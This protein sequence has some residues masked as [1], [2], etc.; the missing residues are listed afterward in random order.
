[1]KTLADLW[2]RNASVHRSDIA[3]VCGGR[4]Y[5]YAS[6]VERSWRLAAAL[7]ARSMAPPARIAILG[8]NSAEFL[9]AYGAAEAAGYIAVPLNWRLAPLELAAVLRDCEPVAILFAAPEFS[10]TVAALGELAPARR[11]L[12]AWGE[13]PGWAEPWERVLASAPAVAPDT[14]PTPDDIAAIIY[15]SGTTG[16]PKGV[17]LSH[18]GQV[19]TAA[20]MA[21]ECGVRADDHHLMV[22]PLFHVGAK[23]KQLGYAWRGA[24]IHLEP[25]FD[26]VRVLE[27]VERERIT[28]LHLAPV[29]VQMLLDAPNCRSANVSSIHTVHYASAPM[30]VAHLRRAVAAFGPI[31]QQFYGMTESPL[32]TVLRKHEH[33]PLDAPR[34]ASAGRPIPSAEVR[35]VGVDGTDRPPGESGEVLVRS[36]ALMAGYWN[37]TAASLEALAGGWMHTGD[38]GRFDDEGYLHIIDRKKDMLI[39]GGENIYP[40]EV[41]EALTQ[42]PAVAEAAVIGVPDPKW[43]EAVKAFVV[44]RPEASAAERELIAHC[45]SLIAAYKC[46]KS[47]EILRDLP[48]VGTGKVDKKKLRQAWAPHSDRQ[49]L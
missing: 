35:V 38:I 43:G 33:Q 31:F 6:L 27:V 8:R 47:V 22:M 25:R 15:T 37:Q 14:A 2:A 42:H 11:C 48:R 13:A 17:M 20:A 9:E 49:I 21:L 12:I 28:A 10:D 45:R 39:S 24:A 40:R 44:L 7:K 26:P 30:P 36:D 5:T 46:P 18:R 4:R 1:M 3:L 29:M 23:C 19:A 41:E 16:R 32:A 34:L